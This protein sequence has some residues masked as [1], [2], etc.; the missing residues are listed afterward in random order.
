MEKILAACPKFSENPDL[1]ALYKTKLRL[2][3]LIEAAIE[4]TNEISIPEENHKKLLSEK[5]HDDKDGAQAAILYHK[6]MLATVRARRQQLTQYRELAE[7]LR[8]KLRGGVTATRAEERLKEITK[9]NQNYAVILKNFKANFLVVIE[10]FEKKYGKSGLLHM[11]TSLSRA[12]LAGTA[13]EAYI[14]VSSDLEASN[15]TVQLL[16]DLSVVE[17]HPRDPRKVRLCDPRLNDVLL[18]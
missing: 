17:R 4:D 7:E 11:L 16:V 14:D 2:E 9:A 1:Q 18:S 6:Q 3:S 8:D 5:L 15:D 10:L 13:Q 12:L